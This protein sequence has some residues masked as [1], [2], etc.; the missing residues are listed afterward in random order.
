[1]LAQPYSTSQSN[2]HQAVLWLTIWKLEKLT[3]VSC[4]TN[5]SLKKAV[6]LCKLPAENLLLWAN[7]NSGSQ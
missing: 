1:M 4:E 2:Q 7:T 6:V 3:T 5:T